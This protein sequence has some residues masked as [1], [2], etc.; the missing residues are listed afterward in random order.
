[1]DNFNSLYEIDE[2]HS[3]EFSLIYNE[4]QD[5]NGEDSIQPNGGGG[6]GGNGG[7]GNSGNDEPLPPYDNEKDPTL[8]VEDEDNDL[9]NEDIKTLSNNKQNEIIGLGVVIL[10]L[11]LV[12]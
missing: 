6:S 1:M 8:P 3:D 9:I 4:T 10:L 12:S 5:P 2:P 7:S 11:Y